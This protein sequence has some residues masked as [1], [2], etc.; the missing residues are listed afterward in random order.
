MEKMCIEWLS[1]SHR[2]GHPLR[3]LAESGR[4][5][6]F[7]QGLPKGEFEDLF[8]TLLFVYMFNCIIAIYTNLTDCLIYSDINNFSF[9]LTNQA[10]SAFT[11]YFVVICL[12]TVT[13]IMW[14]E[15]HKT[16]AFIGP[17]II[18]AKE[19]EW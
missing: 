6:L 16:D 3:E 17:R 18:F 1:H 19:I 12:I 14:W 13:A 11:T 9:C 8:W 10:R 7:F 4:F 5:F 2:R 15:S